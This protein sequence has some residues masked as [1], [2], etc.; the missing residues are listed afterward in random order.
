M[1]K[2]AFLGYHRYSQFITP[3][4]ILYARPN[5]GSP[6]MEGGYIAVLEV[7]KIEKENDETNVLVKILW[8]KDYGRGEE[9]YIPLERLQATCTIGFE[10]FDIPEGDIYPERHWYYKEEINDPQWDPLYNPLTGKMRIKSMLLPE[11]QEYI[12]DNKEHYSHIESVCTQVGEYR[13]ANCFIFKTGLRRNPWGI[14]HMSLTFGE[15][16]ELYK[17]LEEAI[18]DFISLEPYREE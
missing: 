9:L 15:S 7:L 14:R 6:A 4:T 8:H 16:T 3:G 13:G 18:Y 17:T 2:Y 1:E 10:A 12:Y 11:Q 5:Y